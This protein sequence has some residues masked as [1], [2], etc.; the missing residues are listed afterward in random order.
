MLGCHRTQT[1][2]DHRIEFAQT[3]HTRLDELDPLCHVHHGL[4]TFEGWA[5]VAGTGSRRI[6]G[7]DDPDHPGR[8]GAPVRPRSPRPPGPPGRRPRTAVA[9]D[10]AERAARAHIAARRLTPGSMPG[11]AGAPDPPE[12]SSLFD[13][14]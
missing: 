6:V 10:L 4:K 3:K 1:Q 12:Q 2:N 13:T 5:L 9:P 7:P 11:G 14:C 8:S